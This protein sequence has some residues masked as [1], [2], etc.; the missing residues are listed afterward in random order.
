MGLAHERAGQLEDAIK[1]NERAA[2]IFTRLL[3]PQH[4]RTLK[5]TTQMAWT[6]VKVGRMDEAE[7]LLDEVV[8]TEKQVFGDKS[9]VVASAM[10][11]LGQVYS[12]AG[13]YTEA[14]RIQRD[15]LNLLIN[16]EGPKHPVTLAVR[17]NLAATLFRQG[18]HGRAL[19]MEEKTLK[20]KQDV[21]GMEHPS[22]A[23]TMFNFA[24]LKYDLGGLKEANSLAIKSRDIRGKTLGKD[25]E[26]YKGSVELCDMISEAMA[27]K[28]SM[29][30]SK[31]MEKTELQSRSLIGDTRD[32]LPKVNLGPK[33]NK[34]QPS[35]YVQ[36]GYT[37]PWHDRF[38]Q[39]SRTRS[40]SPWVNVATEGGQLHLDRQLPSNSLL[41]PE[42]PWKDGPKRPVSHAD[43]NSPSN[44]VSKSL[45]RFR[46]PKD[47]I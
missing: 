29:G 46:Y 38:P 24:C 2:E 8:K 4:P 35:L 26:L 21:F 22:V 32:L 7:T 44:L 47:P 1:V 18:E 16:N 17:T 30:S 34:P 19:A 45:S 42:H 12:R 36:M 15:L 5:A 20:L 37:R 14:E 31:T 41:I 23:T 10:H 11:C 39:D 43:S 3:G 6:Y 13:R 9:D 27:T 25:H 33:Q 28:S 40:E